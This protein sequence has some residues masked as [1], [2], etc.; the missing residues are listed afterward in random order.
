MSS[1]GS[2]IPVIGSLTSTC[3]TA[4]S[5]SRATAAIKTSGRTVASRMAPCTAAKFVP[6]A[7]SVHTR[8]LS[9]R[10]HNQQLPGVEADPTGA[11][12]K[13][14]RGADKS[15]GL[16]GQHETTHCASTLHPSP[17][18][19]IPTCEV[20]RRNAPPNGVQL[21]NGIR[22]TVR[23][24]SSSQKARQLRAFTR[25]WRTHPGN[26]IRLAGTHDGRSIRFR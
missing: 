11:D 21:P 25:S 5:L 26:D 20:G 9:S 23:I 3:Q 18:R 10:G 7:P 14:G 12:R 19:R 16:S 24:S 2:T 15:Y 1:K 13:S 22:W 4:S 8:V 6:A 17:L